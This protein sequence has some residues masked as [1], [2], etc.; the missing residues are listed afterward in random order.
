MN[1]RPVVV[2]E[3]LIDSWFGRWFSEDLV[4][5]RSNLGQKGTGDL[6]GFGAN[7]FHMISLQFQMN[8]C[9]LI[10]L[11]SSRFE[12]ENQFWEAIYFSN[13]FC[14]P[15]RA[16]TTKLKQGLQSCQSHCLCYRL[17]C[18]F[19][20]RT[21]ILELSW[22]QQTRC[23]DFNRQDCPVPLDVTAQKQF[24]SRKCCFFFLARRQA[25]L[26]A[27]KVGLVTG[28]VVMIFVQNSG[29]IDWQSRHV[30]FHFFLECSLHCY[31]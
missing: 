27:L 21:M 17:L 31:L 9:D 7:M 26:N 4:V 30:F 11:I 8:Q 22:Q 15:I 2:L 23:K 24:G 10:N 1:P 13:S 19:A 25:N 20:I 12:V 5:R 3:R 29:G 6:S 16:S 14:S 28:I 18:L